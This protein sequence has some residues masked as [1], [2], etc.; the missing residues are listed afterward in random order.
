M[1]KKYA[2]N[3]QRMHKLKIPT[4]WSFLGGGHIK[5]NIDFF[6]VDINYLILRLNKIICYNRSLVG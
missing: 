6:L 5:S 1:S 2:K 3:T 4:R